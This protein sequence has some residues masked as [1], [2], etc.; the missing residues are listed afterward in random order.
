MNSN[1]RSGSVFVNDTTIGQVAWTQL[2]EAGASDDSR[3]RR[4][5]QVGQATNY[6]KATGFGFS[7]PANAVIGGVVVEVEH[8]A[9]NLTT[10]IKD[11]SIKLVKG[12]S[13]VGQ[14][15]VLSPSFLST[16]DTLKH[17]VHQPTCGV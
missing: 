1:T 3:A 6:L 7:I 13:I 11:K 10:S 5:L 9:G 17:M 2:T 4:P 16:S 12:N 14:N 8:S 15:R